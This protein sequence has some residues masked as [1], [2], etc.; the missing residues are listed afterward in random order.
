METYGSVHMETSFN[1][2]GNIIIKWILCPIVAAT[3]TTLKLK[4]RCRH[5]V[6]EPLSDVKKKKIAKCLLPGGAP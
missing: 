3:A 6:N 2:N 1:G 4:W 5:N